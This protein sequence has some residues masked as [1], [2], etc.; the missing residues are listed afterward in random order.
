MWLFLDDRHDDDDNGLEK[1]N[2]SC[3]VDRKEVTLESLRQPNGMTKQILDSL[4]ICCKNYGNG[5]NLMAKYE[6]IIQL[7]DHERK[8]CSVIYDLVIKIMKSNIERKWTAENAKNIELDKKLK[9]KNE[10]IIELQRKND[11]LVEKINENNLA[12]HDQIKRFRE[13]AEFAAKVAF[14]QFRPLKVLRQDN[15]PIGSDHENAT[16]TEGKHHKLFFLMIF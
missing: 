13:V 8:G 16:K 12:K 10:T 7:Q 2:N 14:G 5:C 11:H 9:E 4:I 6:N 15:P 1:G 3:P